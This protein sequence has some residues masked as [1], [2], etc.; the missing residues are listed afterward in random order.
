MTQSFYI[1]VLST[2]AKLV[3]TQVPTQL[4][5]NVAHVTEALGSLHIEEESVPLKQSSVKWSK[6][7]ENKRKA[8]LFAN[9]S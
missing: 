9:A 1:S 7:F 8:V 6:E 4:E 2:L 5:N 3:L